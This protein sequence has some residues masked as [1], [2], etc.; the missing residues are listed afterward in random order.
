MKKVH[1]QQTPAAE[2]LDPLTSIP[3]QRRIRYARKNPRI[4]TGVRA[5]AINPCVKG[6]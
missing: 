4:R 1:P 2:I 6:R 5:G 3:S